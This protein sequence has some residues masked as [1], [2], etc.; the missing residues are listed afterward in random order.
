M[1][2]MKRVERLLVMAIHRTCR[3][4]EALSGTRMNRS[5]ESTPSGSAS[6]RSDVVWAVLG[7]YRR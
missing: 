3:P 7:V 5:A 1:V 6:L 2:N 4:R